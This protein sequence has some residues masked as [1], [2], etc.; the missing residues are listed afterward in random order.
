[1]NEIDQ[2]DRS[3][4]SMMIDLLVGIP[5]GYNR[6]KDY[7]FP[8]EDMPGPLAAA[9]AGVIY[10]FSMVNWDELARSEQ[11]DRIEQIADGLKYRGLPGGL[12]AQS[13]Y[14]SVNMRRRQES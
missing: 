14:W 8:S 11:L 7:T 5:T 9:L 3:L 2:S 1:M 4:L 6:L 13:L 12:A 10:E